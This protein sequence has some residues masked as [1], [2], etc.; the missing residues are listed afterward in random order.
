MKGENIL[1]AILCFF[2]VYTTLVVFIYFIQSKL[3]FFPNTNSNFDLSSYKNVRDISFIEKGIH[4]EGYIYNENKVKNGLIFYYGGNAV[5]VT[6]SIV[7]YSFINERAVI[8]FN[9]R[10]YGK[11]SGTSS[12]E[13]IFIDA[14]FIF[15]KFKS[16]YNPPHITLLG[17]S[18]GA[19]VAC[20]MGS[21]Y[22]V[23]SIILLTPYD[24]IL[25]IARDK[26]WF[27]PIK[28]ILKHP[29]RSDIYAKKI[30]APILVMIANR[31]RVISN[32]RSLA[33]LSFMKNQPVL[34]QFKHAHH[35]NVTSQK[36]FRS[37][38]LDFLAQ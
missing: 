9:Y 11:S 2:I 22:D 15:N 36:E 6:H 17:R 37:S 12:Q 19:G 25:N 18:L 21:K 26:Y 13:S 4:Y 35:N 5:D 3:L 20:Y 34:V 23:S 29:F 30:N 33:L 1:K 27:L 28:L 32:K 10:G 38:I 14:D 8:Y 31:D 24:S 16:K 7:D